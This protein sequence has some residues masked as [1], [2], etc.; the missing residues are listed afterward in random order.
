MLIGVIYHLRQYLFISFYSQ[1]LVWTRT[2]WMQKDWWSLGLQHLVLGQLIVHIMTW[3]TQMELGISRRASGMSGFQCSQLFAHHD[4]SDMLIWIICLYLPS[5]T[6]LTL[7]SWSCPIILFASGVRISGNAWPFTGLLTIC[8]R[9]NDDIVVIH[10]RGMV[11]MLWHVPVVVFRGHWLSCASHCLCCVWVLLLLGGRG[12]LL[13]GCRRFAAGVVC[14]GGGCI[15][16]HEGVLRWWWRK[17]QM[18]QAVTFVSMLFKLACITIISHDCHT[19]VWYEIAKVWY[20][21]WYE[22]AIPRYG[23]RLPR[24]G[25]TFGITLPRYGI[26]LPYHGM[27]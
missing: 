27:V 22:I 25:M 10:L 18:S 8:K 3:S 4:L 13:G 7:W 9:T 11:L 2:Q 6:Q 12:H 21:I 20:D 17:K 24:Y 16:W 19:T 23:M 1:A 15:T 5:D 14:S 26:T